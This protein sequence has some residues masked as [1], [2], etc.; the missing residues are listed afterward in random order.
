MSWQLHLDTYNCDMFPFGNLRV[1]SH[2][3]GGQPNKQG[4]LLLQSSP[5][6]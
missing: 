4:I 2:S 1:L 5:E 3:V 6:F